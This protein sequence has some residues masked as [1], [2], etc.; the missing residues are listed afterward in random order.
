MLSFGLIFYL[1][2][3]LIYQISKVARINAR[4][5]I[6]TDGHVGVSDIRTDGSLQIGAVTSVKDNGNIKLPFSE[7]QTQKTA[8]NILE[9]PQNGPVMPVYSTLQH[10]AATQK[11]APDECALLNVIKKEFQVGNLKMPS[12]SGVNL[13]KIDQATQ[14]NTNLAFSDIATKYPHTMQ[15]TSYCSKLNNEFLRLIEDAHLQDKQQNLANA[16]RLQDAADVAL[17]NTPA[18]YS[19]IRTNYKNLI[20]NLETFKK[21]Q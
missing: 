11:L 6:K 5:L 4:T 7:Q 9:I 1:K 14:I 13:L 20:N 3:Q 17:M 18:K 8:I 15:M 19:V 21:A 16:T 12:M 10:A 2:P